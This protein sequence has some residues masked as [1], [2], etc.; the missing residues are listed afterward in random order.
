MN[1]AAAGRT[2]LRVVIADD[3]PFVCRLLAGYLRSSNEFEVVA[4]V[5]QGRQAVE[6]VKELHPDVVTLDL[7]MPEMDGIEVLSRIMQDCPTPVVIV[8]GV[9]GK[10]ATRTLQALD[11]GAVD[12]VLKYTPG[13]DTN[14]EQLSK[15]VVAKVR[16]AA[17]IRVIRLLKGTLAPAVTPKAGDLQMLGRTVARS[18][19][20]DQDQASAYNIIVIGASTGGPLAL[21]ELIGVLPPDFP[22][23]IVIVQHMPGS[24]T[25]VLASQLSRHAAI[26]VKEADDGDP[27]LPGMA[28]VAPGGFHLILQPALRVSLRKGLD[29]GGHC[30]AID[31]TMESAARIY[32][33]RTMGV[34]LTGMGEDGASGMQSI[35]DQGGTTFAQDAQSCV[36][37]GM[38]HRARERGVVDHVAPPA[39]IARLLIRETER[40]AV[41]A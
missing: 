10:A 16:A 24:F 35:H 29:F 41:H 36:V 7:T 40:R 23:T 32:G 28:L 3:S 1:S 38:P 31:V 15:E 27:L 14:A 20:R 2:K 13:V 5:H 22:A 30:P 37:D 12:F 25:G 19:E 18:R 33:S 26:G 39:E 6:K 17:G 11:L 8:S 34:L 9:S 4:A 21:R